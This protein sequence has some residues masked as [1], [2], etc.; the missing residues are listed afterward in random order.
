MPYHEVQKSKVIVV[1]LS[2]VL[3]IEL[4]LLVFLNDRIPVEQGRYPVLGII[5]ASAITM[6]LLLK[7]MSSMTIDLNSEEL[8]IAFGAL[9]VTIPVKEI[10]AVRI[11]KFGIWNS[12]GIGIRWVGWKRWHYIAAL[13][14][15]VEIQWGE[16]IR[17][18][19]T[20]N[21]DKLKEI[22]SQLLPGKVEDKR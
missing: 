9:G 15:G 16:K 12:G 17:G 19:T 20:N 6:A 5:A 4:F 18:F 10:T 8:R 22:F 3:A 14:G 11:V 7:W 13:G 2:A 21:P 1:V